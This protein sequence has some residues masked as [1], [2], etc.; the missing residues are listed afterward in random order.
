MN[1]KT[2]LKT[3]IVDDEPMARR[4]L[5]RLC[6]K[7]EIVDCIAVCDSAETALKEIEQAAI[8]LLFLDIEM[9]GLSGIELLDRLPYVPQVIFTTSN[10]EYAFE[11]FEYDVTDFLK[12][13]IQQ[14]RFQRSLEK[15]EARAQ[16]L[17]AVQTG[18]AER[19]IYIKVDG[20]LVRLEYD[21]ILYFENVGDYIKVIT[22]A[23]KTHVIHGTIK[24]LDQKLVYPRFLKV[25]RS[26]IINLDQVKDIEDNT[27]VIGKKVIPIS[28]AHKPILLASLNII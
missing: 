14:A 22:T 26:Y 8:D 17:E 16:Q 11:A 27:V 6:E 12:K 25:H 3:L 4:S 1:G 7:A 13:P 28:R 9:P 24:G 19:E 23:E 20:R 5:E 15:A 2:I 10:P 21:D 18:S